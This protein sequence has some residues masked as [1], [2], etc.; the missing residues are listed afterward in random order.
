MK[1]PSYIKPGDVLIYHNRGCDFSDSHAVII[2]SV[3][4]SVTITARSKMAINETYSDNNIQTYYQWLHYI[5]E[6]DDYGIDLD[7]YEYI[8]SIKR[9]QI[10]LDP[11]SEETGLYY[12]YIYADI[13]KKTSSTEELT[14]N[15]ITST[16]QTIET[17]CSLYSIEYKSFFSCIINVC[18]YPL[19]NVDIFLPENPPK[20][21]KIGFKNW[22][23][24]IGNIPYI[25]NKI[26]NV[27]CLPKEAN[28]F[29][30]T[31]IK[32]EGCE[33]N[34][35]V[36]YIYGNWVDK[37]NYKIPFYWEFPLLIL[38]GEN[39]IANCEY[40]PFEPIYIKC[41]FEGQGII[42]FNEAYTSYDFRIYKI[43]GFSS[44]TN[45]DSCSVKNKKEYLQLYSL[46]YLIISIILLL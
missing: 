44:D 41:E 32:S 22:K 40:Q 3:E 14:F 5:D 39:S 25:T 8:V 34:K 46:K 13:N 15:L 28:T 2:T 16:G 23:S 10:D 9:L 4:P 12:Y 38:N 31:S 27:N 26:S 45:L 21:K 19:H 1:P 29:I 30:P 36:F 20:S 24:V 33:S 6:V 7:S 18:V 43:N 35:N 11:C 42:K 37:D 17:T